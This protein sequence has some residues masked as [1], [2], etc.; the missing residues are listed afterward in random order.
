MAKPWHCPKCGNN[1]SYG[2][3]ARSEERDGV[4][5]MGAKACC[6]KCGFTSPLFKGSQHAALFIERGSKEYEEKWLR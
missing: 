3:R 5:V 2:P 4:R 6:P 1:V